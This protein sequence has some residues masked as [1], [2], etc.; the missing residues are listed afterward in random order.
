M[1]R[2]A[3]EYRAGWNAAAACALPSENPFPNPPKFG[4][5]DALPWM[6][7]KAYSDYIPGQSKYDLWLSG[8]YDYVH[9]PYWCEALLKYR[10]FDRLDRTGYFKAKSEINA[11]FDDGALVI[12]DGV[13]HYADMSHV[14]ITDSDILV[15]NKAGEAFIQ[16]GLRA[17]AT[18][19]ASDG[20]GDGI[21]KS[22]D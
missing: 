22:A 3:N 4:T 9:S 2:K 19:P 10:A 17:D 7:A 5:K 16:L 13:Y 14:K 6:L 20:D 21:S 11:L 18:L 15:T 8:Y 12:S 1:I